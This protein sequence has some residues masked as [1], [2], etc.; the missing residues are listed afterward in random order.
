MQERSALSYLERYVAAAVLRSGAQSILGFSV[1]GVR[2]PGRCHQKV[3]VEK[4]VA[5]MSAG[6]QAGKAAWSAHILFSY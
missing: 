6:R 3:C 2:Q 1:E 4:V 5:V